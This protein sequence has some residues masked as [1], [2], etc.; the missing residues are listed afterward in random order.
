MRALL[1]IEG[2]APASGNRT[3]LNL[4][5]VLDRS[6]SMAGEKLAAAREAAVGLVRRLWP[7]DLVSDVAY[8]DQV[9]IVAE[10]ETGR[11]QADLT[12][13]IAAIESGGF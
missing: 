11:G 5:L 3:P 7:E 4:A 8:D 9:A 10:P 12:R 1:T 13:R 6:G 2:D